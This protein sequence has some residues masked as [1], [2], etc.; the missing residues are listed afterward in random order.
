MEESNNSVDIIIRN[1]MIDEEK[2]PVDIA[3]KNDRII[4]IERN[5]SLTADNEIQ[6]KQLITRSFLERNFYLG[7][8][9]AFL[10]LVISVFI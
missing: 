10:L 7:L 9:S 1:I 8:L 4:A 5:L 3:I 2:N 6:G